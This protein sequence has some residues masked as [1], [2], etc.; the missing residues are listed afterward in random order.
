[1][2]LAEALS[3]PLWR[4]HEIG[5]EYDMRNRG[6]GISSRWKIAYYPMF[7]VLKNGEWIE[8]DEPRV[9]IERPMQGGTDFREVPIRFLINPQHK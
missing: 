9:L 3:N 1:M 8:L 7:Q 4:S 5:N 2:N 6:G